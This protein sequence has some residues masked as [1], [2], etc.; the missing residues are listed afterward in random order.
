MS[1]PRWR[2]ARSGGSSVVRKPTALPAHIVS[3][4]RALSKLGYCSR[5]EAIR[6]IEEGRVTVDG[7]QVR[8]AS[9]RVDLAR[10]VLAVAGRDIVAERP[11][12]LMLNK[13]RGVVTTRHDPQ[14]RGTVYDCLPRNLPYLSPVGRLDKASEGLLF[15]TNDTAWAEYLLN[16]ASGVAKTYHVKIDRVADS[17][18]L[19]ALAAPVAEGG[20]LLSAI[21]VEPLR[22]SA[23][24]SWIEIVLTEG[25]NRQVR[26]MLAAQDAEVLR[27]VRVA[28]GG[29]RLGELAK[30]AIRPLEAEEV[31][32]L[33]SAPTSW[34]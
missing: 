24:S 22:S 17:A 5:T 13:P 1:H 8:H 29:I 14:A 4:P 7:R 33:R 16:P 11:V 6:L 26:R 25:R 21:A 10:S 32:R 23:R 9:Q 28:I 3:V 15:M 12:Y 27:L 19:A 20:E 34:S 2:N 30:G 31:M 18:L